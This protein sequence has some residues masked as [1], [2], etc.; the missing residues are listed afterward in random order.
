MC[1]FLR[2]HPGTPLPPEEILA[3]LLFI[4]FGVFPG[5]L[6][7]MQQVPQVTGPDSC[8]MVRWGFP[9]VK[10]DPLTHARVETAKTKQTWRRAWLKG[11][12]VV[13]V[14]AWWEGSWLVDCPAGAYLATLWEETA[15]GPC[16]AILTQPPPPGAMID[17]FP[18]PLTHDGALAWLGGSDSL[19]DQAQ[20]LRVG[21]AIGEQ[22]WFDA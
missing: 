6:R 9:P 4:R 10:D 2:V 15:E 14:S 22:S 20:G 17:R 3:R 11:R 1:G 18:I 13:P 5:R 16:L 8:N 21:G 19:D 12:G 7:P